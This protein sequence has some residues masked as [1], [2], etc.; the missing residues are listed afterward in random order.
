MIAGADEAVPGARTCSRDRR[1]GRSAGS[2][3]S[4]L[5]G[6]YCNPR[7]NGTRRHEP[8][9]RRGSSPP[10]GR[11]GTAPA[12]AVGARAIVL[13]AHRS[14]RWSARPTRRPAGLTARSAR[15][16]VDGLAPRP[17]RGRQPARAGWRVNCTAVQRGLYPLPRSRT[18]AGE[19]GR[20][21]KNQAESGA[22]VAELRQVLR[23]S[24]QD[25]ATDVPAAPAE[26]PIG[27]G[28]W[29]R[30]LRRRGALSPWREVTL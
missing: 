9:R 5:G 24:R 11:E 12:T 22:G 25:D 2:F 3:S 13:V 1:T 30:R 18:E 15:D 21:A 10:V 27:V 26:S 17:R 16:T 19:A 23:I 29:G 28:D 7:A 20:G 8:G 4:L 6:D 14:N